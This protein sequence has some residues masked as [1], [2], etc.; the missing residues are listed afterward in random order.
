[1]WVHS[2]S[3]DMLLPLSDH[4]Y[5]SSPH[6]MT[7]WNNVRL[8]KCTVWRQ[9][10]VCL[11]ILMLM[12]RTECIHCSQPF[13]RSNIIHFEQD[14]G[15]LSFISNICINC[16]LSFASF[17]WKENERCL[18]CSE[19]WAD[20]GRGFLCIV[21]I[22]LISISNLCQ[23]RREKKV[24]TVV[25]CSGWISFATL[26][27]QI[28]CEVGWNSSAVRIV[29]HHFWFLITA[30]WLCETYQVAFFKVLLNFIIDFRTPNAETPEMVLHC[31]DHRT[32]Q[33]FRNKAVNHKTEGNESTRKPARRTSR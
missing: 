23:N 29:F 28:C 17:Q 18:L 1:M 13:K 14:L 11:T 10:T 16:I 8:L 9:I 6:L 24:C 26:H 30:L 12:I 15:D 2:S 3:V 33:D 27:W 19:Q 25:Y 7:L 4:R 31:P 21:L 32:P 20:A 22:I 5:P